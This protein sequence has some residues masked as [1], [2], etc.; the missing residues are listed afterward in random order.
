VIV[1]S[2]LYEGKKTGKLGTGVAGKTV[3]GIVGVKPNTR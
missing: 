1:Q 3:V 2:S